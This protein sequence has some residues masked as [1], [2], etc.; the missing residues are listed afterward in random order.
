MVDEYR[1]EECR[2]L[3]EEYESMVQGE[4]FDDKDM[5]GNAGAYLESKEY[6]EKFQRR[7]VTGEELERIRK[8]IGDR[9]AKELLSQCFWNEDI[10]LDEESGEFHCGLDSFHESFSE[11]FEYLEKDV[12]YSEYYPV[13]DV[14]DFLKA[15]GDGRMMI[16]SSLGDYDLHGVVDTAFSMLGDEELE[17]AIDICCSDSTAVSELLLQFELLVDKGYRYVAL[18]GIGDLHGLSYYGE[19][20]LNC[21]EELGIIVVAYG[22]SSYAISVAVKETLKD[23]VKLVDDPFRYLGE[24][25]KELCNEKLVE[26]WNHYFLTAHAGERYGKWIGIV[27]SDMHRGW[28]M[29]RHPDGE[30]SF[31]GALLQD[32]IK[33]VI[34]KSSMDYIIGCLWDEIDFGERFWYKSPNRWIREEAVA[35]I[36]EMK[37]LNPYPYMGNADGERIRKALVDMGILMEVHQHY[38]TWFITPIPWLMGIYNGEFEEV[39]E[40]VFMEKGYNRPKDAFRNTLGFARS[41]QKR[42]MKDLECMEKAECKHGTRNIEWMYEEDFE[43]ME[44][45]EKERERKCSVRHGWSHLGLNEP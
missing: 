16:L 43:E 31:D 36:A 34:W 8:E 45:L 19:Q 35:A 5:H 24:Y 22:G 4:L 3:I 1:A 25:R 44:A 40:R 20:I 27:A 23:R 39:F 18:Y 37:R 10:Y 6:P 13:S 9:K 28:K 32:M 15:D 33:A 29:T 42:Y 11:R 12:D 30:C 17:K 26:T 7:W 41:F 38:G 2:K 14:V 21:I